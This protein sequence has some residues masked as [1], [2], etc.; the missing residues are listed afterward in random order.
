[1]IPKYKKV[2]DL[3]QEN[4][5][6]SDDMSGPVTKKLTR[7]VHRIISVLDPKN[8]KLSIGKNKK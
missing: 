2:F 7:E 5:D 6:R 8:Y 4:E 1:M 3:L